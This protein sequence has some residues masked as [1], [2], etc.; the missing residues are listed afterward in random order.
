[1]ILGMVE[2]MEKEPGYTEH[3][4]YKQAMAHFEAEEWEDAISL[5]SQLASEFPDDEGLQQILANL[6]LKASLP[7]GESRRGRLEMRRVARAFLLV[8]GV[9]AVMALV[10]GVS[11]SIYTNWLLPARTLRDQVTQLRELHELARGY[12]AAS[13]YARAADLYNEILSQAP[14]DS[15]A[16]A[17]LERVEELQE[18]TIAYDSALELTREE[19]WDEAL[20]AWQAILAADS[21]FRDVKDWTAFI[22]EQTLLHSL[23]KDAE[24]RY[25]S[26]D[27]S[28]AIEVLEQVRGQ[29]PNYRRD[30]VEV[31]LVASLVNLAK[32]MLS[33][34]L[35]VA[36]L[37][38]ETMELFDKAIKIR[39][40]DE[41]VLM[42][43]AVAEA[44]LK[45]FER[46]QEEDWEGA[47]EELRFAYEHDPGYAAGKVVELLY[48]ANIRCGDGRAEAGDFQGA[49]AC[50]EAASELPVDDVS[51]ADTKYADLLPMLTPSPTP[52]P[53]VATATPT[54]KP[55]PT[56]TP[57]PTPKPAY[58]FL[59]QQGSM[60]QGSN[61]DTI[62]IEGFV[63]GQ[64]GAP[65]SNIVVRLRWFDNVDWEVS[66]GDG[67]WGFAPYGNYWNNPERFVSRTDF[68]VDIVD[69]VGGSVVRSDTLLVVVEHCDIAG[70]S[71]DIKFVYQY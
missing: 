2:D 5:F 51:E 14:D 40:Q 41:S 47:V 25:R 17:G 53:R 24:L 63:I 49:L 71:T 22:E 33:E 44:Y 60:K 35:D 56:P 27:W 43:R 13:D 9:V 12:M 11:Y 45:G 10:A 68:Y 18:L 64:G 66:K 32:Q 34:A 29:N 50:Y 54:P 65:A 62:Y 55:V 4:L 70:Q 61:C 23:F 48:L 7:R 37:Y 28:G 21:N 57:T 69:Q 30:D 67:K 52:R 58:E 6:R 38:N 59:Y 42:E 20:E 31:F 1:M 39:P 36:D 26:G 46:F 16:A 3:P 15:T 8:L 19:R